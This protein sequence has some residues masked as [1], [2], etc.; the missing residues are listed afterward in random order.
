MGRAKG[1][2]GVMTA[3]F[4]SVSVSA[5]GAN[6]T[7]SPKRP[8]GDASVAGAGANAPSDAL[9]PGLTAIA[10]ARLD[11]GNVAFRARQYEQALHFYRV[12]ATDVPN[13]PAPWY[14]V[15]MVAQA[16]KNTALAD[17][18]TKAV[19]ARSGGGELLQSGM[20]D[21]HKGADNPS[22]LPPDHPSVKPGQKSTV[23]VPN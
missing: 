22:G 17:S 23:K 4:V 9:P 10:A 15:Y 8:L 14:G 13:H 11:S 5:C 1:F 6:G 3:V 12:A 20:A 7:D 2:A 21:N 18:A 19:A 16:M